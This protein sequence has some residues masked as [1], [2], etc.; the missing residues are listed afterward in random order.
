MPKT[1]YQVT[2]NEKYKIRNKTNKN[3]KTTWN[4][5]LFWVQR[6]YAKF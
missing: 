2:K 3:W 4:N 1:F 6:L 5:I